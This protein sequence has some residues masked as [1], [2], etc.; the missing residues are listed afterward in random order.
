MTSAMIFRYLIISEVW[1]MELPKDT[2]IKKLSDETIGTLKA[3]PHSEVIDRIIFLF[4]AGV[5]SEETLLEIVKNGREKLYGDIIAAENALTADKN[6]EDKLTFSQVENI[7]LCAANSKKYPEM[8]PVT[9]SEAQYIAGLPNIALVNGFAKVT[10]M[11]FY[12]FLVET[13]EKFGTVDKFAERIRIEES[14]ENLLECEEVENGDVNS[15]Y[16]PFAVDLKRAAGYAAV[17][18]KPYG[19]DFIAYSKENGLPV[20]EKFENSYEEYLRKFKLH[21][22][23]KGYIRKRYICGDRVNWFDYA[24]D[25]ESSALNADHIKEIDLNVTEKYTDSELVSKAVEKFKNNVALPDNAVIEVF[26]N[27]KKELYIV[28]GSHTEPLDNGKLHTMLFDFNKIWGIIQL[29]SRSRKI[30]VVNDKITIPETLMNEI[31]VNE[32]EY[33]ERMIKEQYIRMKE[34]RKNNKLIQTLSDIKSAAEAERAKMSEKQ[35][36]TEKKQ[37]ELAEKL[38]NRENSTEG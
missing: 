30:K 6:P 32:R 33:A 14:K 19:R 37:N 31:D 20:D 29:C 27:S 21:F 11:E 26:H 25:A 4:G 9:F 23:V 8:T 3:E 5:I 24:A 22:T 2:K 36:V 10:D 12:K 18:S 28:K 38:A 13:G 16:Y 35:A 34:Q 1:G 7:L 17:Y 15:E